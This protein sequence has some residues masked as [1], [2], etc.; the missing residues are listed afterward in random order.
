MKVTRSVLETCAD[1]LY[2]Y[3]VTQGA[4]EQHPHGQAA[5]LGHIQYHVSRDTVRKDF[6]EQEVITREIAPD[7]LAYALR[8]GR[9]SCLEISD[10]IPN[11]KTEDEVAVVAGRFGATPDHY[12]AWISAGAVL[13]DAMHGLEH[14]SEFGA[15][16]AQ[17]PSKSAKAARLLLHCADLQAAQY[18]LSLVDSLESRLD[19]LRDRFGISKDTESM[20]V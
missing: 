5:N 12:I 9:Y 20:Q 19:E 1:S 8:L 15:S 6:T 14:K 2:Y 18:G 7:A 17:L 10:L 16:A 11:D 3:D 4:W 13:A